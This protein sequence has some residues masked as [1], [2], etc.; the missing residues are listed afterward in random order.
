MNQFGKV[1]DRG[2][3]LIRARLATVPRDWQRL[4]GSD[5]SALIN[6]AVTEL[7]AWSTS[8]EPVAD[9]QRCGAIVTLA[10]ERALSGQSPPA[11]LAAPTPAEEE[12]DK[13]GRRPQAKKRYEQEAQD[14]R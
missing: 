7:G 8:A 3:A 2:I 1:G 10:L 6:R 14:G 9:L 12:N 11:Q 5:V 4:K 13:R